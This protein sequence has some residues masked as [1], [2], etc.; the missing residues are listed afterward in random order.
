M[1]RKSIYFSLLISCALTVSTVGLAEDKNIMSFWGGIFRNPEQVGAIAPC[2]SFV[3]DEISKHIETIAM[4]EANRPLRILEAGGG[5]GALTLDIEKRLN[6]IDKPYI[7]DVIEIDPAYCEILSEKFSHNPQIRIHCVDVST[8]SPAYQYDLIISSLPFTS[9]P[10]ELVINVVDQFKKLVKKGG[11][12]SYLEYILLADLKMAYLGIK[13]I[14][15]VDG[16]KRE[17]EAKINVLSGFKK[18]FGIETKRVLLNIMPAQI[19]HL[20]MY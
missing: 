7:L 9:L 20:K 16:P 14:F 15:Q 13:E 18:E 12:I 3:A 19:H 4:G 6:H 1:Q 8:W 2:S 11:F 10:T 17:F 5:C